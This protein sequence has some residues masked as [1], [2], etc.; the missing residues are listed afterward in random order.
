MFKLVY[1][2]N[3]YFINPDKIVYTRMYVDTIARNDN[4]I[5]ML[6]VVLDNASILFRFREATARA[7]MNVIIVNAVQ[8][9]KAIKS[10]S[11]DNSIER[12]RILENITYHLIPLGSSDN[13]MER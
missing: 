3:E 6:E 9:K 12:I 1:E 8:D 13:V 7:S 2:D 11:I 5:Y 4:K 10:T